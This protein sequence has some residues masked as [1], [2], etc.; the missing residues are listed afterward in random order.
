ML[1]GIGYI[2]DL[3]S[4]YQ[5]RCPLYEMAQHGLEASETSST[6]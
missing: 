1:L 6:T 2:A 4:V 5:R 3:Y